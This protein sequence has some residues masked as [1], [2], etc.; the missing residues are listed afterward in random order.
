MGASSSTPNPVVDPA[1][2]IVVGGKSFPT[3]SDEHFLKVREF[4][5]VS[6][7][8]S[9]EG[10]SFELKSE[11]GNMSEGGGKGGNLMGFTDDKKF[12]IKELNK[13]DHNTMLS[14]A[15]DYAAHI[16]HDDGSLLCKVLAHFYHPEKKSNYMV[17]DNVIPPLNAVKEGSL[18]TLDKGVASTVEQKAK[19]R[20]SYD[21]KGCNDDKVLE[22]D[23]ERVEEVHKR[24][25]MV[26]MWCGSCCWSNERKKYFDGKK[27][28]F[29][30][31]FHVTQRQKNCLMQWL[32]TAVHF[33]AERSLMDYSL[34]VSCLKLELSDPAT[35]SVVEAVEATREKHGDKGVN[36]LPFVS[37]V[38]STVTILHVG[39]IDFLQDWTCTKNIAMAI[40]VCERNKAT[41]PPDEYGARFIRHFT[42]NFVGDAHEYEESGGGGGGAPK[43]AEIVKR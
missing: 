43:A 38:G 18:T 32:R 11:G 6:I 7:E 28:A 20:A 5:G 36:Q 40:K 13:T 8:S 33:L 26:H 4:F 12:I 39:V 41:V 34:M 29:R 15:G 17:M 27:A 3:Y 10:F 31:V 21:L 19:R 37:V 23:G 1:V 22:R 42:D 2:T 25:W 14:C 35:A 9:T 24:I 16:T 30:E